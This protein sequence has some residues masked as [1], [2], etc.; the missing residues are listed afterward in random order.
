MPASLAP[1]LAVPGSSAPPSSVAPSAVGETEDD[2]DAFSFSGESVN[3]KEAD[4]VDWS[5]S[6]VQAL[7]VKEWIR[8]EEYNKKQP[9]NKKISSKRRYKR[10][11][12][13]VFLNSTRRHT[14]KQVR[15]IEFKLGILNESPI[16]VPI[17][18]D[19]WT[20]RALRLYKVGWY[21]AMED[22]CV[23]VCLEFFENRVK[24]HV[25]SAPT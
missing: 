3:S 23:Y 2:D 8:L 11:A 4:R 16:F 9:I 20:C 18:V 10:V 7:A 19:V 6:K 17:D 15:C 1:S 5:Q 21:K 22:A 24:T 12:H 14:W 13:V 25:R